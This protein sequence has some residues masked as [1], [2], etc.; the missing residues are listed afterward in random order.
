MRR[1]ESGNRAVFLDRMD[2]YT[3]R[4][5]YKPVTLSTIKSMYLHIMFKLEEN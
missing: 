5:F 4:I 2:I 3:F 1:R